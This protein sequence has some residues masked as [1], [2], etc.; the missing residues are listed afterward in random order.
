MYSFI[1]QKKSI[2]LQSILSRTNQ[3]L[4]KEILIK[5]FVYGL[6]IHDE[7]IIHAL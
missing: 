3:L 5:D 6:K 7:Q 2:D 4:N 1:S